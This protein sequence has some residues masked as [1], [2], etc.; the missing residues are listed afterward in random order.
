MARPCCW[1]LL[2][3]SHGRHPSAFS[4][5]TGLADHRQQT[6]SGHD[7]ARDCSV[8]VSL[9]PAGACFTVS[10]GSSLP[11]VCSGHAWRASFT[12]S[13]CKF[14]PSGCLCCVSAPTEHPTSFS[15]PDAYTVQAGSVPVALHSDGAHFTVSHVAVVVHRSHPVHVRVR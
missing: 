5:P 8:P 9:H 12:P 7:V 3:R 14:Y 4:G 11:S 15:S 6:S 1:P 10:R 2:M 13:G